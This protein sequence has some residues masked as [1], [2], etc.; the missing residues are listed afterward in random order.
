MRDGLLNRII[1]ARSKQQEGINALRLRREELVSLGQ[2]SPDIA[3]RKRA[4]ENAEHLDDCIRQLTRELKGMTKRAAVKIG[5]RADQGPRGSTT[6]ANLAK[7]TF[8]K[9]WR[10]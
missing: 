1:D 5:V 7:I 9:P 2:L 3:V 8:G 6:S 10:G 4:R